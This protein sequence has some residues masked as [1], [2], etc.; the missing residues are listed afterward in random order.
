MFYVVCVLHCMVLFRVVV[1]VSSFA[2]CCYTLLRFVYICCF[3]LHCIASH[4]NALQN[5]IVLFVFD[6]FGCV[7]FCVTL[8]HMASHRVA[9]FQLCVTL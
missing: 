2:L 3:A 4:C 5:R 6:S 9:M 1:V 7:L 8:I